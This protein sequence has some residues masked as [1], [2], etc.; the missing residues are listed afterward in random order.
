[1]KID[2]LLNLMIEKIDWA[3]I[4]S[5]NMNVEE[6]ASADDIDEA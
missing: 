6:I 1:M 5:F 4:A 2:Y 3:K